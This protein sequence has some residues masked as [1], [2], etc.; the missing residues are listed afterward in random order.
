MWECDSEASQCSEEEDEEALPPGPAMVKLGSFLLPLLAAG[1]AARSG[2]AM[3]AAEVLMLGDSTQGKALADLCLGAEEFPP[4][5]SRLTAF[6]SRLGSMVL[7]GEVPAEITAP[8]Q[9]PPPVGREEPCLGFG[10][11]ETIITYT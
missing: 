4:L 10:G 1:A 11:C 8:P 9:L 3:G 6:G 2:D 7:V 5:P